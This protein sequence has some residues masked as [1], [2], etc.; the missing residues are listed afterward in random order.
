[1]G[2][3]ILDLH[4]DSLDEISLNKYGDKIFV[5]GDDAKLWNKF[6]DGYKKIQ[7]LSEET[8]KKLEEL[9]KEHAENN[10]DDDFEQIDGVIKIR[11]EFCEKAMCIIDEI[12]GEGTAKK[13]F[14]E[15]YEAIPDFVP[16]ENKFV[17]FFDVMTPII[18]DIFK[19]KME[20]DK[21]ESKERMAKYQPQDHNRSQRKGAK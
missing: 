14:R 11:T 15:Y 5:S 4:D 19:R 6:Y 9:E 13:S 3:Y 18:E 20:R 7:T 10:A 21:K 8:D 16:D 17:A 12:F 2:K 1:M